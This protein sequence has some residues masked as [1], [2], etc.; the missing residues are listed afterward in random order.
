VEGEHRARGADVVRERRRDRIAVVIEQREGDGPEVLGA[1]D[2]EAHVAGA[3]GE[4]R[5]ARR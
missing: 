3:H 2:E 5:D 4:A 1:G